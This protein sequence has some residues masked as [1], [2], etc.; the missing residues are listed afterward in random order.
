MKFSEWTNDGLIDAYRKNKVSLSGLYREL[1]ERLAVLTCSDIC[2]LMTSHLG[3]G[4]RSEHM[5]L[6]HQ[7]LDEA[8]RR[9]EAGEE[10]ISVFY[11]CAVKHSIYPM[12][13]KVQQSLIDHLKELKSTDVLNALYIAIR[14][15]H[16]TMERNLK[17][18]LVRR[19][20]SLSAA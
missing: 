17:E 11:G 1:A 10:G 12:L 2:S 6:Q 18:E 15:E 14:F 16:R 8:L 20:Y 3:A 7:A 13:A 9:I 5:K 4:R 19:G